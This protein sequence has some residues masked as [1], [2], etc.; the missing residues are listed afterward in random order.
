M[1]VT[2]LTT[3]RG[4]SMLDTLKEIAWSTRALEAEL[5]ALLSACAA[6]LGKVD[7][8]T[9]SLTNI[10]ARRFPGKVSPSEMQG[11]FRIG[12]AARHNEPLSPVVARATLAIVRDYRS[13]IADLTRQ[14][15][16]H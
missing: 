11:V 4:Q 7:N 9:A 8:R 14:Q 10:F 2:R 16:R 13:L 15:I 3:K 5:K 1:R 12:R 6:E